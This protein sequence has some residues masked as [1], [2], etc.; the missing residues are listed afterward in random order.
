MVLLARFR[1]IYPQF[2]EGEPNQLPVAAG[3]FL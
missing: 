1:V 2:V 3:G